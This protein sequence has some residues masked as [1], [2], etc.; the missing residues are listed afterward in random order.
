MNIEAF[1]FWGGGS[2]SHLLRIRATLLPGSATTFLFGCSSRA[3]E[4]SSTFSTCAASLG[5]FSGGAMLGE[6]LVG[7]LWLGHWALPAQG[8]LLCGI[9]SPWGCLWYV[10]YSNCRS[11]RFECR[12]L[13]RPIPFSPARGKRSWAGFAG[14]STMSCPPTAWR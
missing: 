1:D 6:A 10:S 2:P 11:H 7:P 4:A 14:R 12:R 8:G 13:C 5:P 3:S 9:R